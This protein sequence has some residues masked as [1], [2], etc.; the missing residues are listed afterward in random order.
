VSYI[1]DADLIERP[2]A[3]EI[4]QVATPAELPIVATD[5]MTATLAGADR[6][7][8]DSSDLPAA[9]AALERV[10]SA[11]AEASATIDASLGSRYSLPLPTTPL[12]LT[13]LARAIV[14]YIL[15]THLLTSSED[16]PIIR[17]YR[18]A[19]ATL[20]E[21]GAGRMTLG[22]PQPAQAAEVM[23]DEAPPLL[24]RSAAEYLD[25]FAGGLR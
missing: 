18:A 8:F 23:I 3:A 2:G 12:V 11:I 4:A 7:G 25:Y 1:S 20:R 21:I 9:D 17:D 24:Q 16:S 10:H 13:R 15:H 6:S 14:R 22:L 19:M 5:L